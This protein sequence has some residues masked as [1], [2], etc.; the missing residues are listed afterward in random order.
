VVFER[1]AWLAQMS[2]GVVLYYIKLRF[3]Q[4]LYTM[5]STKKY[6]EKVV[7]QRMVPVLKLLNNNLL[8]LLTEGAEAF[9]EA[10]DN[11]LH[12]T[13]RSDFT[14]PLGFWH[15]CNYIGIAKVL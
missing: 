6:W 1:S 3:S 2:L 15:D 7:E 12:S 5:S 4:Y 11:I 13:S 14:Y 8:K 10:Y 9:N